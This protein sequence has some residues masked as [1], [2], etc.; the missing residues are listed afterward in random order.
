M[1]FSAAGD[2]V[3]L[4]FEQ[5]GVWCE[6]GPPEVNAVEYV[7]I[8]ATDDASGFRGFEPAIPPA[9]RDRYVA[10]LDAM[11]AHPILINRPFVFTERGVRLCRPSEL[12]LD[13]LPRPQRGA[14]TKEDGERIADSAGN[15]LA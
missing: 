5:R 11:L 7:R 13:I 12:V 10:L 3:L 8:L 4:D 15:R 9:V 1:V 6:F 14:F 2:L